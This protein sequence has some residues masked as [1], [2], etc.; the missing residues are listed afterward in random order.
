V[1]SGPGPGASPTSTQHWVGLPAEVFGQ[2]GAAMAVA[3][4][5]AE[6]NEIA[7]APN[8]TAT[9]RVNA[10]GVLEVTSISNLYS[11]CLEHAHSGPVFTR[12]CPDCGRGARTAAG[13]RCVDT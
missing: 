11:L 10:E 3:G 1:Q 12:V 7:A 2:S 6:L 5:A 4:R 13:S 9:I 8:P